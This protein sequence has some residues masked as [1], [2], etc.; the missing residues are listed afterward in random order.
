M[1]NLFF[2]IRQS[3]VLLALLAFC[4]VL[5][6]QD[7]LDNAAPSCPPPFNAVK[8]NCLKPQVSS[9]TV[10]PLEAEFPDCKLS[11]TYTVRQCFDI[12]PNSPN[13]TGVTLKV[14]DY[15]IDFSSATPGCEGLINQLGNNSVAGQD[16]LRRLNVSIGRQLLDI[17]AQRLVV[18]SGSTNTF[19]CSNP[20]AQKV[21]NAEFHQSSCISF[22]KGTFNLLGRPVIIT[23]QIACK[24]SACC[25][26]KRV[27]CYDSKQKKLV[28]VEDYLPQVTSKTCGGEIPPLPNIFKIFKATDITQ[29]PCISICGTLRDRTSGFVQDFKV[30]IDGKPVEMKVYPNPSSNFVNIFFDADV[31]GTIELIDLKG[32]LLRTIQTETGSAYLDVSALAKGAYLIKFT[33]TKGGIMNQKISI[34]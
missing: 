28:F 9:A 16:F 30:T 14:S 15:V 31:K 25:G 21:I 12:D 1:K 5:L 7:V 22:A 33:D 13:F 11:V 17:E 18:N 6:A 2:S 34:D 23:R 27:Y 4:N 8:K 20:T 24:A 19:D 26:F 32:T 10:S 29:G 3:I